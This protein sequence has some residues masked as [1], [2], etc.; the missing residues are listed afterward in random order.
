MSLVTAIDQGSQL[1]VRVTELRDRL[2]RFL[3]AMLLSILVLLPFSQEIYS[4]VAEPLLQ[5][6]PVGG[7]MIATD[8][9]STFM[10]PLK[11]VL[12]AAFTISM[13]VFLFQVWG[14]IA[15][16]LYQKKR[17]LGFALLS[18]S[19]L[20]FYCGIAFAF[21]IVFPLVFSFFSGATP[22]GV[23]YT[24]DISLYLNTALK[25]FL[26]FGL[27]FEI[28]IATVLLIASGISSRK[29]LSEKRPYIIIS[30][31][32][33]GMILTPPDVVSQALLAIPMLLLFELGLALSVFVTKNSMV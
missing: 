33:I 14:F 18:C 3:G 24:P 5:Y 22:E 2:L 32:A 28:P 23:S 6:L 26:A 25:L 19:V 12:C 11:L 8:V 7:S 10:A 27:A 31:F 9:T 4:L 1:T 13:P 30:C 17:G 29:A 20:L 21:Y 15:P 16:G